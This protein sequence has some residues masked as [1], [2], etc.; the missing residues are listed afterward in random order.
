MMLAYDDCIY[1]Q[2]TGFHD[3]VNH[4]GATSQGALVDAQTRLVSGRGELD[5][6]AVELYTVCPSLAT[7]SA[8]RVS[9][10]SSQP[11][12][13]HCTQRDIMQI[14]TYHIIS[15]HII[16]YTLNG[17][18]VSKLKQTSLSYKLRCSQCQMM[19]SGKDF[20]NSHVLSWRRKVNSDWEDVTSSGTVSRRPC[21]WNDLLRDSLSYIRCFK[22]LN[23]ST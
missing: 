16:S 10:S 20:L 1:D 6:Q 21:C 12:S 7:H 3:D 11:L 9:T 4:R 17:R 18:T 5:S 22:N 23:I 15:Y 13:E 14:I 8:S 19:M 2:H